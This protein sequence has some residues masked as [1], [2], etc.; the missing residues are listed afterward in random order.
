MDDIIKALDIS[1]KELPIANQLFANYI[2]FIRKMEASEYKDAS[3]YLSR[4]RFTESK[5]EQETV[6]KIR[7]L[8]K[9]PEELKSINNLYLNSELIVELYK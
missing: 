1:E 3:I 2:E 9:Y 5:L 7:T 4:C 8:F 6:A